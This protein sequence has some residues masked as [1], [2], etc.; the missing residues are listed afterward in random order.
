MFRLVLHT[1]VNG[2][3]W[4]TLQLDDLRNIAL[5]PF[6]VDVFAVLET[7]IRTGVADFF[8]RELWID[9]DF[10]DD[11]KYSVTASAQDGFSCGEAGKQDGWIEGQEESVII[12][13]L[14][15]SIT[16]CSE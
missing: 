13:A 9:A 4:M 1:R 5:T 2:F 6:V 12:I 15:L 16:I 7:Y 3:S 10:V 11:S 8:L 14:V